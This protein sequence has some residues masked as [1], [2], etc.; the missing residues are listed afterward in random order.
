MGNSTYFFTADEHY[1]HKN[2]I[3]YCHRPFNDIQEMNHELIKRHNEVVSKYDIT[4]H[5]GDF[6]LIKDIIMINE[7]IKKLNGR[8]I[9][10]KGS[11]DT[12]LKN[13]INILEFYDKIASNHIV[14]CHYP[15]WIWP[16]SHYNSWH[17]FGHVHGSLNHEIR[18]KCHDV[19]VDNNNF[20]PFS[21]QQIIKI[22]SEKPD[23]VNRIKFEE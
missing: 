13:N 20:Y 12:W 23:N 22:M 1:Y 2:I 11:H 8:H 14:C 4:I 9:F 3:K 10:I 19:G 7:I 15:L 5:I 16:K 17:L 18:G 6:T 21:K